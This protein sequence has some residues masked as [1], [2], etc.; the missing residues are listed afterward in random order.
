MKIKL[1]IILLLL[2]GCISKVDSIIEVGMEFKKAEKI[3]MDFGATE[4]HLQIR[5][6]KSITG[7]YMKLKI[8]SLDK[9]PYIVINHEE[10][11]GKNI[12]KKISLYYI[13]PDSKKNSQ[14]RTLKDVDKIDL[15]K[16]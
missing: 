16:L 3:L 10:N 8:Y 5:P 14:N 1:M 13:K 15:I 7:K 4:A 6:E 12:I 9:K 11:K 2:G